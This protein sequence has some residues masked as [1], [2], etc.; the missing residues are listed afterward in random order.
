ME[1]AKRAWL[2]WGEHLWPENPP[3]NLSRLAERCSPKVANAVRALDKAIYSPA[4]EFDWV[5]FSPRELLDKDASKPAKAG[6]R[7]KLASA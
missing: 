6:N 4:H 3:G 1:S 7:D 2:R 5:R